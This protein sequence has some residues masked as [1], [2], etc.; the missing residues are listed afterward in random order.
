MTGKARNSYS[1]FPCIAGPKGA[2]LA[3]RE[4]THAAASGHPSL[5]SG[6]QEDMTIAD[7]NRE[8]KFWRQALN[9]IASIRASTE[10]LRAAIRECDGS[11]RTG[12]CSS[13]STRA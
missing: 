1:G 12:R 11:A 13:T 6:G 5:N 10:V 3:P 9:A 8:V 4:T 7:Q 2:I